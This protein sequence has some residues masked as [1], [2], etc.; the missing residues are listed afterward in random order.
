MVDNL[1]I[2]LSEIELSEISKQEH[3]QEM[4]IRLLR[5]NLDKNGL[6]DWHI[7]ISKTVKKLGSCNYPKKTISLS[8]YFIEIGTET[9]IL[10]TILHE[11]AHALCPGDAHGSLWRKKALELGCDGKRCVD[12]IKLNLQFNF[13]CEKGCHA[14]FA[15]RCKLVNYLQTGKAKCKKHGLLFYSV[16]NNE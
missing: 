14:S 2:S 11:I 8:S 10:N 3:K 16:S 1:S 7:R 13:E 12:G 4:A 9:S 6:T 15:R 5:S